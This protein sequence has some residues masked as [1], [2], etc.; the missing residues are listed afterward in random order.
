[1][2]YKVDFGYIA[3]PES[4][5]GLKDFHND[6]NNRKFPPATE[7]ILLFTIRMFWKL[8]DL[9]YEPDKSKS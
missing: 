2:L 8:S 9:E 5:N 3:F 4:L 7:R 6:S 1:M